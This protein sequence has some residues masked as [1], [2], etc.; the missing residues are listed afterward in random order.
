M[1]SDVACKPNGKHWEGD[2]SFCTLEAFRDA[3]EKV[4]PKNWHEE[5]FVPGL[6]VSRSNANYA[7]DE[8]APEFQ[9]G[10]HQ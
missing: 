3:V 1:G 9:K 8:K 5:C 4:R 6:N 10:A 2:E 7:E